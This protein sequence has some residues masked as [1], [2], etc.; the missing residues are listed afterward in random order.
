[1][2]PAADLYCDAQN[3][4]LLGGLRAHPA[5]LDPHPADPAGVGRLLERDDL[6]R[7]GHVSAYSCG[8]GSPLGTAA[9]GRDS[10][11]CGR[12]SSIET[13]A[14]GRECCCSRGSSIETAAVGRECCCSRGSSIGTA[15]VG[16][17]GPELERPDDGRRVAAH[18]TAVEYRRALHASVPAAGAR[19][20]LRH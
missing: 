18:R 12:G 14:V 1:M 9:V 8:R 17:L 19:R 10:Y 7:P 16:H 15:A 20:R 4:G 2:I 3:R 11:S 13:A 5:P 6:P